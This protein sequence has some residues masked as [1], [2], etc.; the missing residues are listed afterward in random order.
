[1]K[2][3]GRHARTALIVAV[4]AA[5][6]AGI[7]VWW[8]RT[9]ERVEESVD[10]PRTGE[11]RSNPLYVLKL[12]LL[13]DGVK[14]Q[15]RP[16]LQRER[17]RLGERDTVLLYDDPRSLTRADADALLAW[18]ARGGHLLLRTPP[19]GPLAE[20]AFIPVLSQL[21]LA[22]MNERSQCV[23]WDVPRE[24]PHVEFCGSRRFVPIGG[25][26]PVRRWGDEEQGYVYA[27]VPHGR[28]MVDVLGDFDFLDNDALKDASHVA[29]A[30]QL[31]AP[32]Y[33][34]GT[35]HLVHAA[36]MPSFWWVLLR[37][38]WMAWLPLLLALVAWL[39]RRA[40]RFGPLLPS[41]AAER[42]SLLE[43]IVAS[44]EHVYRYGYGHVL[45]EAARNAFLAR[46]RRRD[47]RAAAL[48]GETQALLLAQRFAMNPADVRDAL[49]TPPVRDHA[50]FR[51]RIATLVRMRN[52]L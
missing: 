50:A 37:E 10:L 29:L 9:Y 17:H 44:G 47:P 16:R 51:S 31:L 5:L 28:G 12:S 32:N 11:A 42:R 8:T 6:I 4:A 18:V 27:R 24:K 45:H 39:W 7:A 25:A 41:P 43:H 49:S 40:Q 34:A 22:M 33:R 20:D 21:D 52:S 14:A 3:Q 23:G 13:G 15:A 36:Q 46:L 1:M 2:L 38:S 48:A 19:S 35:V 30:R 26:S